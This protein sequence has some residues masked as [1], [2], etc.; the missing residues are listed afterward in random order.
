M[1]K[2]FSLG[3]V[4]GCLTGLTGTAPIY[5]G[6]MQS[7]PAGHNWTG[8][9]AGGNFGGMWG[10]VSGPVEI[11]SLRVDLVL[12]S[13]SYAQYSET[14][15][16]LTGGAQLGYNVQSDHWVFGGEYNFN[17]EHLKGLHTLT[18]DELDITQHFVEGDTFSSTNSWHSSVLARAGYAVQDVMLYATA[19]VA[20][21]SLRFQADIIEYGVYPGAYGARSQIMVGGTYGLGLSWALSHNIIVGIEG[22]YTD[23]GRQDYMLVNNPI[24]AVSPVQFNYAQTRVTGG[25]METTE[26]LVKINYQFA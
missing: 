5:A 7:K 2:G 16:S 4:L 1:R 25:H 19:G 20:V 15:S 21:T 11:E 17:G 12:L 13:T 26:A 23:Y 9:Y 24:R 18:W 8:F 3:I 6:E 14:V 22:R 10:T